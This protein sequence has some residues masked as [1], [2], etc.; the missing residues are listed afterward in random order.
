VRGEPRTFDDMTLWPLT[1]RGAGGGLQAFKVH[2]AKTR[3][4][5]PSKLPV[6]EGHGW[7]YV[8][9][10]RLRLILGESD[11]VIEAGEA[12][13]YPT[14]KPHWFGAVDGPVELILMVGPQGERIHFAGS[15]RA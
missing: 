4:R 8:T 1:R 2:V 12:A 13:E 7:L 10:G 11:F 6:H 5:P 15:D 3:T 14:T 9:S